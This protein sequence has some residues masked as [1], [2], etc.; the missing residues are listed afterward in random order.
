MNGGCL[1]CLNEVVIGYDNG[2][3]HSLTKCS[4]HH[5]GIINDGLWVYLC[6]QKTVCLWD[7]ILCVCGVCFFILLHE[8]TWSECPPTKVCRKNNL[9]WKSTMASC[10][11]QWEL[12][13]VRM[14]TARSCL[15]HTCLQPWKHL[16][17][18][19]FVLHSCILPYQHPSVWSIHDASCC[20]PHPEYTIRLAVL[21]L[22]TVGNSIITYL[23][24][25]NTTRKHIWP[26]E[27]AGCSIGKFEYWLWL[28]VFKVHFREKKNNYLLLYS[29][30]ML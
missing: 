21:P 3:V 23:Q 6:L 2:T 13:G 30:S 14:K 9:Q 4:C 20:G 16:K 15:T 28:N 26:E 8:S 24:H 18:S 17:K 11:L 5:L 29:R 1:V 10:V 19:L 7:Y 27:R 12:K 22:R 25:N